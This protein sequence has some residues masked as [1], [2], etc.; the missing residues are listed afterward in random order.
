MN[1]LDFLGLPLMACLLL[2]VVH[3]QFGLHVIQRNVIFVDLTL[4]QCAALG[5]TVAFMQGHLPGTLGA[6]AW[7]LGL[8]WAGALALSLIRFAPKNVPHEALVGVLYVA[9]SAGG[10]LL[11][12]SAPQGAEHLKQMLTGSILT[13]TPEEVLKAAL[14]YTPIIGLLHL[15]SRRG[16]MAGNGG[17]AWLID[18]LFYA[19]FGV[20]VTSSVAMAGVLLV[21]SFLIIPAVCGK[22]LANSLGRQWAWGIA[23]GGLASLGGLLLSLWA[24]TSP[25]ATLVTV[26][27]VVLLLVMV[28]P[29]LVMSVAVR[30]HAVWLSVRTAAVAVGVSLAWL[31]AQPRADQPL[32]DVAEKAMPALQSVYMR[33][34]E[35]DA[36]ADSQAYVKRYAGE[37]DKLSERER[38]SRWMGTDDDETVRRISSFQQS[39]NEMI[40]GEQF[41]MQETRARARERLRWPVTLILMMGMSGYLLR[42]RLPLRR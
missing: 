12:D 33:T 32:L 42:N 9:C 20:V 35:R 22:L 21:F 25:G 39:Y 10:V 24:D 36:I 16:W 18:L 30:R 34:D 28:V 6:Y 7:S 41:V 8:A 37:L 13:V 4:A 40:K 29:R 27:A 2:I 31:A 11:I 38:N 19:A 1:P 15:A 3:C 14:I 23:L 17:R 5:A 26:F